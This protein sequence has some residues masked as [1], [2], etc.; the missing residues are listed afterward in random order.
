MKENCLFTEE[1]L[2]KISL[3]KFITQL[4]SQYKELYLISISLYS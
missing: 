3:T 4:F 1:E 2:N